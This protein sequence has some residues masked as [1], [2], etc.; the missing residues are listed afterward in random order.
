MGTG[1]PFVLKNFT[2]DHSHRMDPII[3]KGAEIAVHKGME[4]NR[5]NSQYLSR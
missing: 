4:T 3:N 1:V 2:A 5:G